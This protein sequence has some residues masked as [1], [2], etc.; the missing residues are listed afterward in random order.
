MQAAL[1]GIANVAVT[2]ADDVC[3]LEEIRSTFEALDEHGDGRVP[4]ATFVEY[5][6]TGGFELTETE[7]DVLISQMDVEQAGYATGSSTLCQNT[8]RQ[9]RS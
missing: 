9:G 1:R 7:Q 3:M 5:L 6:R 8:C 4:Y 2:V